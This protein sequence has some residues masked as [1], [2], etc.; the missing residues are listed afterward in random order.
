MKFYNIENY[1]IESNIK[2]YYLTNGL[3]FIE[4]EF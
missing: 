3:D 2:C 4:K 1:Q